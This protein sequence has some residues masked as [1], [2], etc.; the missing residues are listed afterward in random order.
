MRNRFEWVQTADWRCVALPGSLPRPKSVCLDFLLRVVHVGA[1]AGSLSVYKR[2]SDAAMQ[3]ALNAHTL[4]V[5]FTSS[6]PP[7]PLLL[8]HIS[9]SL[10]LRRSLLNHSSLP[11]YLSLL[12]VF[13]QDSIQLQRLH[14]HS[15]VTESLQS[16]TPPHQTCSLN[17]EISIYSYVFLPHQHKPH[18]S[19]CFALIHPTVLSLPLLRISSPLS[20]ISHVLSLFLPEEKCNTL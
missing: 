2:A 17:S 19:L 18:N 6:A 5:L 8:Q 20:S 3:P 1:E 10:S 9:L 14:F 15:L 7:I 16:G 13:L 12:S 4:L 11:P